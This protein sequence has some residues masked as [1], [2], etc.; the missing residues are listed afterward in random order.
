MST[1]S[2]EKTWSFNVNNYY[3]DATPDNVGQYVAYQIKVILA[4][5]DDWSVIASSNGTSHSNIGAGGDVDHWDSQSDVVGGDSWVLLENSVTGEQF[6]LDM[7]AA[8]ETSSAMYYSATGAFNADG[9]LT[10]PPTYSEGVEIF[11][12]SHVETTVDSCV[13][14]GMITSDGTCTRIFWETLDGTDSG[15]NIIIMDEVVSAP[16]EWTSTYKRC[17]YFLGPSTTAAAEKSKAPRLVDADGQVWYC[18]LEDAGGSDWYSAYQTAECYSATMAGG[19]IA[20]PISSVTAA[21]GWITGSPASPMSLFRP[22]VDHGGN[23]GRLQDIYWAPEAHDSLDIY[24]G[25]GSGDWIKI[26][27]FIVPWDGST[28]APPGGPPA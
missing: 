17:V 15:G 27:C 2:K 19:N 9:T 21:M 26:G 1:A 8:A 16:S 14:S 13:V 10:A 22:D 24:P 28:P 20:D 4:S 6:C 23:L 7:D 25:D 5:F 18:Y 11:D 3:D 12:S